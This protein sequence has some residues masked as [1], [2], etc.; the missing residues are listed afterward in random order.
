M[1]KALSIIATI[2][3]V[4][5][6]TVPAKAESK[7][8]YLYSIWK[9]TP[10]KV[11]EAPKLTDEVAPAP[12]EEG[13]VSLTP[14]EQKKQDEYWQ[15]Q[16]D[17]M[18]PDRDAMMDFVFNDGLGNLSLPENRFEGEYWQIKDEAGSVTKVY[19][20]GSVKTIWPDGR[21]DA[22]DT[23]GNHYTEDTD[24]RQTVTTPDGSV[25]TFTDDGPVRVDKPDGSKVLIWEDGSFT[26]TNPAGVSIDYD[27]NGERTAIGFEDGEKLSLVNGMF[28]QG[29]GELVGP[30]GA[31]LKWTNGLTP[32][33][34]GDRRYS[35]EITDKNGSVGKAGFDPFTSLELDKEKTEEMRRNGIET[36]FA[37]KS[38]A[39]IEATGLDGSSYQVKIDNMNSSNYKYQYTSP[40]GMTMST[41]VTE[42]LYESSITYPDGS[43]REITVDKNEAMLVETDSN[44]RQTQKIIQTAEDEAMTVQYKDGTTVTCTP[45]G[46]STVQKPDG[47]LIIVNKNDESLEYQGAD[48][49]SFKRDAEGKLTSAHLKRADGSFMDFADDKWSFT[50]ASG[51]LVVSWKMDENDNMKILRSNSGEISF[52]EEG[53]LLLDGNLLLTEEEQ[54]AE[55]EEQYTEEEEEP[56][57]AEEQPKK[58]N[59][60]SKN[61]VP[62]PEEF[63]GVHIPHPDGY[64]KG[65]RAD[66]EINSWGQ[67]AWTIWIHGMNYEEYV[68]YCKK[69]EALPDWEPDEDENVSNLPETYN[70]SIVYFSG[71][72]PGAEHIVVKYKDDKE[73]SF[74]MFVFQTF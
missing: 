11:G 21:K 19:S 18:K 8:K 64:D 42:S 17:N 14:E 26:W 30:E 39:A 46:V 55:A 73:H 3:F 2:V 61:I 63:Y 12:P 27:E 37:T 20:D 51:R 53:R 47:S 5:S 71:S 58:P 9:L 6:C 31:S 38:Y 56:V 24:G 52:D 67:D 34:E 29:K 32:G 13:K 15:E 62:I 16:N 69:L 45:D 33:P 70:D 40:D 65:T 43:R 4:L 23:E 25:A 59:I 28:P 66:R 35:F 41:T 22:L 48:G 49:Q 10:V 44:G 68:T 50:D 1:K 36:G 54:S 7:G 74:V 57:E 72:M 60:S